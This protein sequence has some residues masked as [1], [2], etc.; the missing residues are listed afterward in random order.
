VDKKLDGGGPCK[1][2][3]A[4]GELHRRG[5]E[6]SYPRG[7][8]FGAYV[9]RERLLRPDDDDMPGAIKYCAVGLYGGRLEVPGDHKLLRVGG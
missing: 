7:D 6:I 1:R 8:N 3:I 9:G 2:M 4:E 5:F